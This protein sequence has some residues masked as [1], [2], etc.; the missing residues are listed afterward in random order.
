MFWLTT[1]VPCSY[2]LKAFSAKYENC[3]K[4]AGFRLV[5]IST[6][7]PHNVENFNKR[8]KDSRWP[9]EAYHDFNREFAE[10]MPGGLNGLPQV[11]LLDADGKIVYHKRK[12]TS[13]DEDA[14][15]AKVKE[16]PHQYPRGPFPLS[17]SSR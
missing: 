13:G 7:F 10:I 1:C 14:L 16:L 5:A 8:V 15:L 17:N 6:D 3:Q 11:F 9:F 4:E 12:Y 2:E